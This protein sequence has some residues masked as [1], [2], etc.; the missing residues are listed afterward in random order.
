MYSTH[1]YSTRIQ[2]TVYSITYTVYSVLCAVHLY[3]G[4]S[5][6]CTVYSVQ[7]TVHMYEW[8]SGKRVKGSG[9]WEQGI[10]VRDLARW[11]QGPANSGLVPFWRQ[12]RPNNRTQHHQIFQGSYSEV[13]MSS[14][15]VE[16]R[17]R[18]EGGGGPRV[19]L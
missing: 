4:I 16:K 11:A 8:V 5:A 9:T 1:V 2:Y 15:E 17:R 10:D 13:C 3:T 18:E 6:Q 12:F 14:F 19:V 7:C